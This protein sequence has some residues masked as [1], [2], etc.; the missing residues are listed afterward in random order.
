MVSRVVPLIALIALGPFATVL[1]GQPNLRIL[2]CLKSLCKR[3]GTK[4]EPKP[5]LFGPDIFGWGGGL[6]REGV[7]PKSSVCP[8]K[9]RETKLFGGISRDFAGISWKCPK[10]LREKGLCSILVP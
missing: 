2:R 1:R 10:S 7:G 3:S 5:K 4:K 6:P 8:S 9:P